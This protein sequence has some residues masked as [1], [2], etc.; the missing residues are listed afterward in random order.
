MTPWVLIYDGHTPTER[1]VIM[2]KGT[3]IK[4][5]PVSSEHEQ[6]HVKCDSVHFRVA[7]WF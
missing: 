6:Y 7:I 1:K 4:K 2:F 5:T 3:T